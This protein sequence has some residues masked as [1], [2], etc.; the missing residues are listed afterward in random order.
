MT[1]WMQQTMHGKASALVGKW[2][3]LVQVVD[4]NADTDAQDAWLE[5]V[6]CCQA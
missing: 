4:K 2:S 1:A 3:L 6:F 5:G